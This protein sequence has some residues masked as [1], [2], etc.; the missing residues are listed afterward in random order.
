LKLSGV[1]D[2]HGKPLYSRA[3]TYDPVGNPLTMDATAP[4]DHSPGWWG[5]L[6]RHKGADLTKWSETYTYDSQSRLTKA[7]MNEQCSR[8][9]AYTYDG[10][11]NM[12]SKTTEDGTTTDSYDAADELLS[13]SRQER[14]HHRPDVTNYSYDLNGNETRAG[15][16]RYSYNLANELIQVSGEHG[17]DGVSY[18]YAEDGLM[19]TRSTHSEKTSYA[20]DRSFDTPE[21]AIETD[22]KGE[23]RFQMK[24]SRS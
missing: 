1:D 15:D 22:S 8:N 21:L 16:N 2:K 14:G 6:W 10:V 11:G 5:M 23:G 9:F 12:L 18:S 17:H 3:Y 19:Q 24:D 13:A 7:R 20:W 4:R